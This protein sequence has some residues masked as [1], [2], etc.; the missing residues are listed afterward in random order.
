MV[1]TSLF[2]YS[3]EYILVKETVTVPNTTSAGAAA[4]NA[5]KKAIFKNG[6][7]FTDCI[8]EINNTVADNTK[9]ID[10]VIFVSFNTK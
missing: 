3:D 9:D 8:S 7:P 1:N 4:N 10:V 6:A 5:N 2:N